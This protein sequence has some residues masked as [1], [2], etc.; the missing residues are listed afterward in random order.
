MNNNL[1]QKSLKMNM[2]LNAVKGIMSIIFPLIS[3]PY[4][5]KV[6]GVDNIGKFGFANSVITYFILFADLGISTYAIREGAK[7]RSD[8]E[9]INTFASEM[10]SLNCVSSVCSLGVLF[11]CIGVVPKFQSYRALLFIMSFQILFRAIGVE[12]IYSVYEEYT[13]I[14][15]R[16][17]FFQIIALILLFLLVKTEKDIVVYTR[18]N[19]VTSVLANIINFI[20]SKKFCT[21]RLTGKISYTA[22]MKT[23]LILFFMNLTVSIYVVSDTT[24][25][26]FICDDYT[27]GIYSLS[28]KIYSMIKTVISSVLIVSIPRLS[29]LLNE[30]S[31]HQFEEV[32]T[33][34]YKTLLS[35]MLPTIV[36]IILLRREIILIAANETFLAAQ[37]SLALLGIAM[38]FCMGAWFWGQC[39]LVPLQKEKSVFYITLV[40]AG[41]NI[42]LNFILIPIGKENAAAF[43]TILAEA[44]AYFSC[45]VIGRK[46]ICLGKLRKT[47]GKIL[48]GCGGFGCLIVMQPTDWTG[49]YSTLIV[50][51]SIVI[52]IGIEIFLKNEVFLEISK[53]LK[54]LLSRKDNR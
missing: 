53:R 45:M 21:I 27:V 16:T 22:H 6:L 51:L 23:I 28:T 37:S 44:I 2:I 15:I 38:F 52:Y 42:V 19:V 14:T 34:I 36:G 9:K 54:S 18:I 13:Y 7:M 29:A 46:Q 3:F 5:S 31:R 32:A 1:K 12:W 17:V 43:T 24:I 48:A 40:S 4:A 20:R 35:V 25:I 39:V 50:S 33:D 10:F 26:G 49:A 47:I 8:K 11:L 30:N 41:V